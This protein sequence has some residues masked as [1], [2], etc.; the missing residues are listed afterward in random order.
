MEEQNQEFDIC[1][2]C[3]LYEEAKAVINEFSERCSVSFKSAFSQ[4]SRYEYRY[5]IIQNNR[6]ESLRVLVT[7][8]S[9][10]GPVQTGLDLSLILQEFRPRFAAMTGICAGDRKKVK[11]GDLIIAECAYLY[12]EGKVIVG[13]DGQTTH[14][15]ETKTAAS[16][17]QV[18]QYANG[19]DGWKE[20]LRTMKRARLKRELKPNEE[21]KRF[22]V[23]MASGMAV[24][25][26]NPF[27][28]LRE[29]FHRN[30]IAL[31]M[32]AATFYRALGAASHIHALV[33]KGVSDYGDGS[34]ND[35]YHEYAERASATY[36]LSF[37]QEYVTEQ[38]MPRRDALPSSR[39]GPS[40]IWHVP[41]QRNPFFTGREDLLDLLHNKF[42]VNKTSVLTQTISGLGG[43]GKTQIAVEYAYRSRDAHR[44]VHTLWINAA[45]EETIVAS[46]IEIAS[47]ILSLLE[48]DEIDQSKLVTAVI[49]WLE[50]CEQPWL[51]IFDNADDLPI[52]PRYLPSRGNGSILLTTRS[53]ADIPLTVSIEIDNLSLMEG[54]KLLLLR[55]GRFDHAICLIEKDEDKPIDMATDEATV[56]VIDDATNL[57]IVLH[58][59]P[60]A[61]DQA[62]AYIN[63][64]KCTIADYL[65]MYL[66]H[67]EELLAQ[68]GL[69][70]ANYP[71]SVATTWSLSFKKVEE[72]N[73]AAAELLHLCTF[74]APDRIPVELIK[75]GSTHW[76]PLLQQSA[77]DL[78][79]YSQMIGELL[80]FSLVKR[81]TDT[82]TDTDT[83][84]IH[85]M[86]QTVQRDRMEVEAQKRWAERVV[87]AI[88]DV[89]PNNPLDVASLPLCLRYLDQTQV[90]DN[91]VKHFRLTLIEA[92]ELLYRTGLY[93]GR[94]TTDAEVE[95][96]AQQSLIIR[97]QQLGPEHPDVAISLNNLAYVYC[98][99]AE[100]E[101]A[102]PLY[103][104]ALNIQEQQLGSEHLDV[105]RSLNNLADLY[106]NQRKYEKAEPLY[107]RAL[108]IQEQQLGS[109]HLDVARSLKYLAVLYSNQRKYEKA[110]PLFQRVLNIQE[111]QLGSEHPDVARSLNNLA[112]LYFYQKRYQQAR[113]L[114]LQAF[115]IAV[116]KLGDYHSSTRD[117]RKNYMLLQ[118]MMSYPVGT[119]EKDTY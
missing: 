59:F 84:S 87:L 112:S 36:L 118:Q 80:N 26:D 16:T 55:V 44:Y 22:I 20:P 48:K 73:P 93:L 106:S 91:L 40:R 110:E 72:A 107:R 12:E 100:Y 46:F 71:D 21:P 47:L 39:A 104:R 25:S 116:K 94:H 18:L 9:A 54:T 103:R 8:P 74:L 108:N 33:V 76:P 56:N 38:T 119:E 111:Q 29:Q 102:E 90:C 96:I 3:A 66:E 17:S 32:E 86:V 114:Y 98:M 77:V 50:E 85:R 7:W 89:F 23:P 37:I 27:P 1:I 92:A 78:Y 51:L 43:I 24:R 49:R 75:E 34:K 82:D 31:D 117:I 63:V 70:F 109:E 62:G 57:V 105:A 65:E 68:R 5:T 95:R 35:A 42:A 115:A 14:L 30:T 83:L 64:K 97:E 15:K 41:F 113:L 2:V 60:L 69:Q 28:W 6:Q 58:Q 13:P 101:K 99:R 61:L 19:F 67:R 10:H 81:F 45:N 52:L 88:N 11:L 4:M 53:D 79:A